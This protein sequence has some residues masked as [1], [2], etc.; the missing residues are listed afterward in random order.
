MTIYQVL[1][2]RKEENKFVL[3]S[4]DKDQ[5]TVAKEMGIRAYNKGEMLMP[6]LLEILS[7]RRSGIETK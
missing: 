1:K 3:Y 2:Q 7:P 4:A 6:N 5:I